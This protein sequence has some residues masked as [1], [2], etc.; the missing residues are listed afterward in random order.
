MNNTAG[1]YIISKA[2]DLLRKSKNGVYFAYQDNYLIAE[3]DLKPG[4]KLK[5]YADSATSC[6]IVIARHIPEGADENDITAIA[7]LSC[8]ERFERFFELLSEVF[9][10][11]NKKIMLYAAGANPPA[12]IVTPG[13]LVYSAFENT[14]TLRKFIET[15]SLGT[16]GGD[17]TPI[18]I[19]NGLQLGLGDPSVMNNNFDCFGIE[20][21]SGEVSRDREY[22]TPSEKDPTGGFQELFCKIGDG[23]K[24][25]PQTVPFDN[26]EKAALIKLAQ[27]SEK[28][29][30][31]AA[32]DLSDEEILQKFSTTPGCEV[33]WFAETIRETGKLVRDF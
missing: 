22:F 32:I 14:V 25:R 3:N 23:T 18:I 1:K 33:P 2:S 30:F 13:G 4:K 10:G 24:I 5:L 8:A 27:E 20:L 9:S 21:S 16:A 31:V 26:D 12:P 7:H 6:I 28:Y 11:K 19:G 15:H 29:D 17:T